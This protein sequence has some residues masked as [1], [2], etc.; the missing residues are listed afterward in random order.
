M[1]AQAWQDVL[2]EIEYSRTVAGIRKGLEQ[3]RRGEGIEA[4]AFFRKLKKKSRA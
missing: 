4:G 2:D 3:I 1:D